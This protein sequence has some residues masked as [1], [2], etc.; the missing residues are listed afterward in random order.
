MNLYKFHFLSPPTA[1]GQRAC[2]I[3]MKAVLAAHVGHN[4]KMA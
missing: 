3:K 2:A 4:Y 1:A